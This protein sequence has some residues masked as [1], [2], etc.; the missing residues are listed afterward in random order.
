MIYS[1]YSAHQ[2]LDFCW[3]SPSVFTPELCSAWEQ[4]SSHIHS[5]KLLGRSLVWFWPQITFTLVNNSWSQIGSWGQSSS[6]AN[7]WFGCSLLF[8]RAVLVGGLGAAPWQLCGEQSQLWPLHSHRPSAQRVMQ[9]TLLVSSLQQLMGDGLLI[10]L[11]KNI[12]ANPST[13]PTNSRVHCGLFA[14]LFILQSL[15]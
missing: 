11:P 15:S 13:S 6:Y 8:W 9:G 10:F 1:I 4:I 5:A 2:E 7:S 14:V 12:S 3:E